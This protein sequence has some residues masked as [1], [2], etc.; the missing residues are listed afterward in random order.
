MATLKNLLAQEAVL[1]SQQT[2]LSSQQAALSSQQQAL[3]HSIASVRARIAGMRNMNTAI[4]NFP[5]ETLSAIFEAGLSETSSSTPRAT[6]FLELSKQPLPIPFEMLVSAISRRWRNVALQTPQL[7]TNLYINFAQPTQ[8]LHEL[9]LYRSKTCLLDITMVPFTRHEEADFTHARD[10]GICFKQHMELLTPHVLRWRKLVIKRTFTGDFSAPYSVLAHLYAP[11]LE[12]LEADIHSHPRLAMEVFSGGA[13]RLSSLKLDGVYFRPPQGA[14][15]YL[16]LSYIG[17]P[18]SH[19]QFSQ[20]IRPMSSLTHL[21]MDSGIFENMNH[22]SFEF[23][24]VISLDFCLCYNSV[25]VLHSLDFPA[26][27]KLTF[28]GYSHEVI[29]AVAQ[30]GRLYP[31]V[32]SLT[33]AR[34]GWDINPIHQDNAPAAINFMSLLP[35]VRDVTFQGVDPTRILHTL[36]D[37]KSAETMLWPHL[38]AIT[39]TPAVKATI[40]LKMQTWDYIVKVV[41]SRLQLGTPISHITLSPQIIERISKKRQQWL[42]GK[43]TLIEC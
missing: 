20:L 42:R 10:V 13:P 39:V 18:L 23:P 4:Y 40:A 3:D 1:S 2:A 43:V 38:F 24:S 28:R 19:D 17:P 34:S 11:A 8:G 31:T 32:T 6:A 35:N 5:N 30:H 14:V 7:W 27:K 26:V 36:F 22:P 33:I 41:E 12:T 25:G 15:Q 37:C 21:T 9:Y 16:N 29:G